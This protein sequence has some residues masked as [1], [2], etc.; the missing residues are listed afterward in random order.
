MPLM[1]PSGLCAT[2]GGCSSMNATNSSAR[3]MVD[4][5]CSGSPAEMGH[6]QGS[7]LKPRL[8]TAR[9]D[10]LRKA[11]AFRLRQPRWLPFLGY[12]WLAE[13]K[14]A[15]MMSAVLKRDFPRMTERL[16]GIA[17]GAGLKPEAIL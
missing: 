1:G 5:V 4:F 15:S 16:E 17:K 9:N 10:M 13:R 6:A 3:D 7:A 11:E 12:R 2:I 8:H 14:V